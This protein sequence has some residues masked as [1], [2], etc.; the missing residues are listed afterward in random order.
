MFNLGIFRDFPDPFPLITTCLWMICLFLLIINLPMQFLYR[1]KV[2]CTGQGIN[3]CHF[4]LI[5][6]YSLSYVLIQGF[7]F[8]LF[9][10]HREEDIGKFRIILQKNSIY[11]DNTPQ[12]I[13]GDTVSKLLKILQTFKINY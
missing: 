9:Y 8:S 2:L 6:I 7:L 10:Y 1:Y 12:F 5:Y 3:W 4:S 11:K 13:V